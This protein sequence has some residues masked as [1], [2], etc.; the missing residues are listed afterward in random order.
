MQQPVSVQP[1]VQTTPSSVQLVPAVAT[2][3]QVQP[4]A[5]SEVAPANGSASLADA[6]KKEKQ[7]KACMEL[8]K[9]NPSITCQ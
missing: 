8:A 2:R 1:A 3:G 9:D 6:A 5:V 4:A 7:H